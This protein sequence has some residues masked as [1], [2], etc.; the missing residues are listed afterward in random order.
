MD[1]KLN[2]ELAKEYYRLAIKSCLVFYLLL[3]LVTYF[4]WGHI[5]TSI[6]LTWTSINTFTA[7][8]FLLASFLFKRYGNESNA[9]RW[10]QTY[11]YLVYLHDIP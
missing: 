1:T 11:T 6:L 4:Y 9:D 5:N 7:T 2:L 10:L 8:L 3:G